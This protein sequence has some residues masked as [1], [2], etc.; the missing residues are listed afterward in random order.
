MMYIHDMLMSET[1]IARSKLGRLRVK[2]HEGISSE[3]AQVVNK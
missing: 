1:F 3:L 2:E